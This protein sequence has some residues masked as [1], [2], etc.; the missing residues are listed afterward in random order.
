MAQIQCTNCNSF[1]VSKSSSS[2]YIFWGVIIMIIGFFI[3]GGK[4]IMVL[5]DGETMFFFWGIF[6]GIIIFLIGLL[7]VI[8]GIAVIKATYIKYTCGD[9]KYEWN[10]NKN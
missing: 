7:L 5:P 6:F 10:V 3:F 2:S 9:C 1:N 8:A 4:G